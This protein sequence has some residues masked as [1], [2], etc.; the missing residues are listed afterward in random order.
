MPLTIVPSQYITNNLGK[1][2]NSLIMAFYSVII[3]VIMNDMQYNVIHWKIYF[4]LFICLFVFIYLFRNQVGI[5][6]KQYLEEMI[7]QHGMAILPNEEILKKTDNYHITKLAK[8]IIEQQE[9]DIQLMKNLL[10]K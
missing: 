10:K 4:I 7:E 6:D 5:N 2:Y 9:A 8:N 1:F 3:Q